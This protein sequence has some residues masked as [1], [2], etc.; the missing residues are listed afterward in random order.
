[1]AV[2]EVGDGPPVVLHPGLGYASWCWRDLAALLADRYRTI[3][4]DPRGAGRSDKPVGPYSIEQLADDV[5]TLLEVIDGRPAHVVGH[6]MGGYVAQ[7]L[8]SRHPDAVRSLVLL[9]SSP[10]GPGSH[11]VP[12]DT[13]EVWRRAAGLPPALFARETF[14]YSF[15]VGW[16]EEHVSRYEDYLRDRLRWPTP[17]E[18]WQD[19]YEACEVFLTSGIGR[20]VIGQPTLIIHG[21]VDRVVPVANAYL[22]AGKIP[23]SSLVV[24]RDAGHNLMLEEPAFVAGRVGDFLE[25]P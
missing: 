8:A 4:I 25:G 1:M 18:R 9:S 22:L 10:G 12:E 2:S 24:L 11:R 3:S 5:A 23:N 17:P 15:R 20:S 6:S 21:A 13:V 7:M 19:Q 14:P 16:P